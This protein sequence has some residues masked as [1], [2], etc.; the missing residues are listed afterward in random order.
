MTEKIK[1]TFLGT[2]DSIPSASRNHTSILLT[3]GEE[4]LLIDCGEGT[5]RQIRKARLN[6]CKINRALITHWH[7]DH[8]LGLPG[9][10]QTLVLSG[11]NKILEVYGPKGTK[12]FMA[13]FIKI[14]IPVLRIKANVQEVSG[15]F[16]ENDEFYLEALPVSHGVPCNAY[17]FVKKDLIR[18][19]KKKLIKYGI[20]E[21]RHL[22][23]IK[24]GKEIIY[25]G[26]KYLAKDLTYTEKGKKICFVLDTSYNKKIVEFVKDADIL[27]CEASYSENLEEKAKD[28]FHL[29]SK[30]AAQ[31]ASEARVKKLVLTHISARYE[32]DMKKILN[33]AKKIFKNSVLVK[34]LDKIVL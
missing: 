19:D 1:L 28:F 16:F 18:I 14:F 7:G 30:Q 31:I 34:D 13:N 33:E 21:G 11:Y 23:E 2:A 20:K 4:N 3:Y 6:P 27:V 10:F 17:S 8:V 22:G 32:K 25:E 12:E 26:K 29:T 15:I 9:L 5:Q 24:K